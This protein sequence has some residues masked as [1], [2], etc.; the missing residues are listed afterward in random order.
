MNIKR[1]IANF[2]DEILR[3]NLLKKNIYIQLE[4]IFSSPREISIKPLN[5]GMT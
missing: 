3:I 2:K 5:V 1:D 4:I